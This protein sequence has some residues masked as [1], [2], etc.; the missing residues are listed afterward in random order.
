MAQTEI[1]LITDGDEG[2]VIDYAIFSRWLRDVVKAWTPSGQEP[3]QLLE[4]IQNKVAS[5]PQAST[6]MEQ[7]SL[8]AD[9]MAVEPFFWAEEAFVE[10]CS[11]ELLSTAHK[12][13]VELR[14]RVAEVENPDRHR[15]LIRFGEV[16]QGH[17]GED[18]DAIE[19]S[20]HQEIAVVASLTLVKL[21]REASGVKEVEGRDVGPS[22]ELLAMS[23]RMC[24]APGA[25]L[26]SDEE[27][28]F[29]VCRTTVE[30]V[31]RLLATGPN[32]LQ[33]ISPKYTLE[34]AMA[35][36]SNLRTPLQ[37]WAAEELQ[38][39]EELTLKIVLDC[40]LEMICRS[41]RCQQIGFVMEIPEP[42][43]AEQAVVIRQWMAEV[44]ELSKKDT[45]EVDR[46]FMPPSGGERGEEV[47]VGKSDW[48]T[49]NPL[50]LVWPTVQ[51]ICIDLA[52]E[53]GVVVDRDT[54]GEVT[55]RDIQRS[56]AMLE[57]IKL[58]MRRAEENPDDDEVPAEVDEEVQRALS[59]R[60]MEVPEEG[61]TG[62]DEATDTL[63]AIAKEYFM[64]TVKNDIFTCLDLHRGG[65]WLGSGHESEAWQLIERLANATEAAAVALEIGDVPDG[66]GIVDD[67]GVVINSDGHDEWQLAEQ[68]KVMTSTL[69][70][71]SP[72]GMPE[73]LD[74]GGREPRDLLRMGYDEE[75]GE[76]GRLSRFWSQYRQHC[77]VAYVDDGV[78]VEGEVEYAVSWAEVVFMCSSGERRKQF[79]RNPRKYASAIPS[80]S[81]AGRKMGVAVVGCRLAGKRTLAKALVDKIGG[82]KVI[83]RHGEGWWMEEAAG[84]LEVSENIKVLEEWRERKDNR[85]EGEGEEE[86]SA[87]QDEEEGLPPPEGLKGP[88]SHYLLVGPSRVDIDNWREKVGMK[89][90]MVI[91]LDEEDDDKVLDIIKGRMSVRK[92]EE[93][94][95]QQQEEEEDAMEKRSIDE[96]IIAELS[97]ARDLSTALGVRVI[98]LS[99]VRSVDELT[100]TVVDDIDPF[101]RDRVDDEKVCEG[102]PEPWLPSEEMPGPHPLSSF[103]KYS[104]LCGPYCPVT[105]IDDNWLFPGQVRPGEGDAQ[106]V[107]VNGRIIGMA[108]GETKDKFVS[109]VEA[110]MTSLRERWSE[111]GSLAVPP[112]RVMVIGAEGTGVNDICRRLGEEGGMEVIRL[113]D[114]YRRVMEEMMKDKRERIEDDRKAKKRQQQQEKEEADGS[115]GEE[116]GQGEGEPPEDLP[117]G[118]EEEEPIPPPTDEEMQELR[119]GA[120]LKVLPPTLGP[121]VIDATWMKTTEEEEGGGGST[122]EELMVGCRRLPEAAVVLSGSA[123][124]AVAACLDLKKIDEEAGKELERKREERAK[125]MEERERLLAL[126]EPP[127]D[128][129]E[130]EDEIEEPEERPSE[131]AKR[132]FLERQE[133]AIVGISETVVCLKRMG[134]PV[135]EIGSGG[136]AFRHTRHALRGHVFSRDRRNLIF[137]HVCLPISM[138]E[139]EAGLRS[140]R[141]GLSEA[142]G[143]ADVNNIDKAGE[144]AVLVDNRIIYMSSKPEDLL[145]SPLPLLHSNPSPR[146]SQRRDTPYRIVVVGPPLAGM[147]SVA[148][149]IAELTGAVYLH[150]AEVLES[151]DRSGLL[152]PLLEGLS[153]GEASSPETVAKAL[154]VRLERADCRGRGWVVDGYPLEASQ[155]SYLSEVYGIEPQLVVVL[156]LNRTEFEM[157][158]EKAL[159][160][161]AAAAVMVNE[162]LLEAH[163]TIWA[164]GPSMGIPAYLM[165]KYNGME[166]LMVVDARRATGAVA[167]VVMRRCDEM[168]AASNCYK[169]HARG[170]GASPMPIGIGRYVL[171]GMMEDGHTA[172]LAK[173]K[174]CPVTYSKLEAMVIGKVPVEYNGRLYWID[175]KG[176]Y[177]S[178]FIDNPEEFVGDNNAYAKSPG[179]PRLVADSS[180][181]LEFDG[182]C[183]VTLANTGQ[184]WRECEFDKVIFDGRRYCLAHRAA[185]AAFRRTPVQFIEQ[186]RG[187]AE[188]EGRNDEEKYPHFGTGNTIPI[189]DTIKYL[190]SSVSD[191]LLKAVQEVGERRPLVPGKGPRESALIY[192]AAYLKA[193]NPLTLKASYLAE[194]RRQALQSIREASTE[195]GLVTDMERRLERGATRR[196]S[197]TVEKFDDVFLRGLSGGTAA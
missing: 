97:A 197:L 56:K 98:R 96:E 40:M 135:T 126:P 20:D 61:F 77:P 192:L 121:C 173:G 92:E 74:G 119:R 47:E 41:A 123:S 129:P 46:M 113:Q 26:K 165:A 184:A 90:A 115:E 11:S 88:A 81:A 28:L 179:P 187:R 58:R 137:K 169:R 138:S 63:E 158:K 143:R 193:N 59:G 4:K 120:F 174:V 100:K 69:A 84:Q 188:V 53:G 33:L 86:E 67:G 66:V 78:I 132:E 8:L 48:P 29:G 157:R 153:H 91:L 181:P 145:V 3:A 112:C 2:M 111:G 162:D 87:K 12:A 150:P 76:A 189:E 161:Q 99:M 154:K 13:A 133:K 80:F 44:Q 7:P 51:H 15:A 1:D 116:Q 146:P 139:V 103:I 35:T 190:K 52:G 18:K 79:M 130:I 32:G 183:V 170:S 95:Q 124:D 68:V 55:S 31:C 19:R 114:R 180:H 127:E 21:A 182:C 75:G 43:D 10:E 163:W 24:A 168:V 85:P 178:Q 102:V 160:G 50:A 191:Q 70:G 155:L 159:S 144:E 23:S 57:D 166:R 118:Q 172:E 5:A 175:D 196:P 39:G 109:K 108:D 128:I 34:V 30:R 6:L 117:E 152:G 194:E 140:G 42:M 134:V 149:Q 89:I 36:P 104:P 22:V 177:L 45:L 65:H 107:S 16:H 9:P 27:P 151:V 167:N 60:W 106:W 71:E 122:L 73:P 105:L 131:V 83:E 147:T 49:P 141:V 54:G 62:L 64:D 110:C 171:E 25:L 17:T 93:D 72:V 185:L 37:R 186:A 148:R 136:L 101:I 176:S 195:P 38:K 14:R 125:R 164:E 142:F 156:E 94:G 82:V